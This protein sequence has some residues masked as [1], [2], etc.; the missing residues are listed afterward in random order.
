[1]VKTL[2]LNY[3]WPSVRSRSVI[4]TG[5]DRH[6]LSQ[7]DPH[8]HS[9]FCTLHDLTSGKESVNFDMAKIEW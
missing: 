1:M 4:I 8:S 7:A 5:L 6:K 9:L 2:C 3:Q